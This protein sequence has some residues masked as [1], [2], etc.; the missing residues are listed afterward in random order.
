MDVH[1][2]DE[3]T[4]TASVTIEINPITKKIIEIYYVL[5]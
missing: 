2:R 3:K 1:Y 5:Y 4:E